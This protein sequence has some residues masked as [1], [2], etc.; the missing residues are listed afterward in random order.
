MGVSPEAQLMGLSPPWGLGPPAEGLAHQQRVS[1]RLI[2]CKEKL[3]WEK[4]LK[5]KTWLV[6]HM[7]AHLIANKLKW[8]RGRHAPFGISV[9]AKTREHTKCKQMSTCIKNT[10]PKPQI[11][12]TTNTTYLTYNIKDLAYHMRCLVYSIGYAIKNWS[13]SHTYYCIWNRVRN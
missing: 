9:S 4:H 7:Q 11:V 1:L 13:I 6:P 8:S 10:S 5:I 3:K 12:R 2:V